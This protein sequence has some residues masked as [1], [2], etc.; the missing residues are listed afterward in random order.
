MK[1]SLLLI[2]IYAF[3]LPT[4]V[5]D[6]SK[7]FMI[8]EEEFLKIEVEDNLKIQSKWMN[9][10][11]LVLEKKFKTAIGKNICLFLRS[12]KIHLYFPTEK[13]ACISKRGY[14]LNLKKSYNL[15]KIDEP[16][17]LEFEI[18]NKKYFLP[19]VNLIKANK[20]YDLW[21]NGETQRSLKGIRFSI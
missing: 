6:S 7:F 4:K 21:D 14:E 13:E 1:F 11:E 20:N 9:S 3:S 19:L 5:V 8:L 15:R 16:Q 18:N 10:K 2:S 17:G 12:K